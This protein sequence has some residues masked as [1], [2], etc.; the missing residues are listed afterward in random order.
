MRLIADR[1]ALVEGAL[2]GFGTVGN[3]LLGP[4]CLYFDSSLARRQ[5][6]E[7]AKSLLKAAGREGFTFTLGA[8][9]VFPAMLPAATLFAQQAAAAGVTVKINTI[10]PST[11]YTAASGYLTRPFS[12][13]EIGA[14]TSLLITYRLNLLTASPYNETHWHSSGF[15]R[16][17]QQAAA[18][19]DPADAASRW[20]AVQ[21]VQ[22]NDGGMIVWGSTNNLDAVATNVHGASNNAAGNMQVSVQDIWI[23]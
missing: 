11:Y 4:G 9:E 5:D 7:Q 18:A 8:S 21:E 15:D 19:V 12:A 2:S 3:D 13:D 10:S 23:S 22:F 1:P 17:V 20:Q 6:I 16:M 14:I